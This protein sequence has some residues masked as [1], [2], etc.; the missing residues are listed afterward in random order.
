MAQGR[1]GD[2]AREAG[3]NAVDPDVEEEE[4]SPLCV[5]DLNRSVVEGRAQAALI[6]E[7]VTFVGRDV[8]LKIFVLRDSIV[9]QILVHSQEGDGDDKR[10]KRGREGGESQND[11][12]QR[13]EFFNC[14]FEFFKR[15]FA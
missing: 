3:Q 12:S 7:V 15:H 14:G 5:G 9:V 2:A 4:C 13:L 10:A 8:L 6:E 11:P 1:A